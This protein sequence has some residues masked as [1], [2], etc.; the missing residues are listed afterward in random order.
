MRDAGWLI[1]F[2]A[3]VALVAWLVE[4]ALDRWWS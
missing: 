1:V 4:K 3:T 2:F